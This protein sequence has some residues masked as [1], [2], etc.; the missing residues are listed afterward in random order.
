MGRLK[1]NDLIA[2]RTMVAKP[3]GKVMQNASKR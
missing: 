3:D 2:E 1:T